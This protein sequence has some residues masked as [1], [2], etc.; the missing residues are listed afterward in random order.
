MHEFLGE[1]IATGT[2]PLEKGDGVNITINWLGAARGTDVPQNVG[3]RHLT[4]KYG[5]RTV[6][7]HTGDAFES[8]EVAR[9][10]GQNAAD[11]AQ[12]LEDAA[13]QQ[14]AGLQ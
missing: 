14:P 2:V 10:R 7:Q 5:M 8:G 6:Q 4:L 9:A 13:Q 1:G 12:L 3:A 11:A